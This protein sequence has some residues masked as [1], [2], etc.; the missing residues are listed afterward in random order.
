MWYPTILDFCKSQKITVTT[1]F[2][3]VGIPDLQNTAWINRFKRGVLP[4]KQIRERIFWLTE[5]PLFEDIPEITKEFQQYKEEFLAWLTETNLED[6]KIYY[7]LL[8]EKAATLIYGGKPIPKRIR[9]RDANSPSKISSIHS[10]SHGKPAEEKKKSSSVPDLDMLPMTNSTQKVE[11]ILEPMQP[12][13]SATTELPIAAETTLEK[14]L[15]VTIPFEIAQ[16]LLLAGI[17]A[18]T[19]QTIDGVDH[20]LTPENFLQFQAAPTKADVDQTKRLI[21]QLRGRLAFISQL[22]DSHVIDMVH[23]DLKKEIDELTYTLTILGDKMPLVAAQD[24]EKKRQEQEK[25]KKLL[26][27]KT[28][29]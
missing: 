19:S 5:L 7:S 1:L 24:M 23:R 25:L 4:E 17:A 29:P 15:T 13:V 11:M 20:I 21:T 16:K 2:F 3:L 6:K 26:G 28:L 9:T 18:V 8:E 12:V 14:M 10:P 27:G 22:T